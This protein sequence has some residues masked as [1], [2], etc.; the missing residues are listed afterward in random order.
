MQQVFLLHTICSRSGLCFRYSKKLLGANPP[1]VLY[2][3]VHSGWH[4]LSCLQISTCRL[5]WQVGLCLSWLTSVVLKNSLQSVAEENLQSVAFETHLARSFWLITSTRVLCHEVFGEGGD[6]QPMA[7]QGLQASSII[8]QSLRQEASDARQKDLHSSYSHDIFLYLCLLK[9]SIQGCAHIWHLFVPE[10]SL[11]LSNLLSS[12][13]ICFVQPP[14]LRS[15]ALWG[16][17]TNLKSI[18]LSWTWRAA[19]NPWDI[20]SPCCSGPLKEISFFLRLVYIIQFFFNKFIGFLKE[21]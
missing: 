3:G 16:S 8:L 2:H 21:W 18:R 15:N 14:F 20:N 6:S 1:L 12:K 13:E 19:L 17:A 4:W 7:P 9:S 10:S 5:V 11:N